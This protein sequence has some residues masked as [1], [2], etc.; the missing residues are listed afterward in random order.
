[1]QGPVSVLTWANINFQLCFPDDQFPFDL[2]GT[3]YLYMVEVM[4]IVYSVLFV[5]VFEVTGGI[6]R[7]IFSGKA[8][9]E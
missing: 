8:K 3:R 5:K 1:M 7:W 2:F 4:F 6:A 9:K